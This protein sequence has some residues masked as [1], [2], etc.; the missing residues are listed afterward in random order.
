M[1]YRENGTQHKEFLAWEDRKYKPYDY[2]NNGLIKHLLSNQIVNSKNIILQYI[3]QYYEKSI[4]FML[5]YV[6]RLKNFKNYH[7]KNR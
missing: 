3:L 1:Q 5:K 4:I 7:A 2:E 6:D